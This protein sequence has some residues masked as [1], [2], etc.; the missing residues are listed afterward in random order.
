MSEGN[1]RRNAE[2]QMCEKK[3]TEVQMCWKA[4][5]GVVQRCRYVQERMQMCQ[6]MGGLAAGG[7]KGKSKSVDIYMPGT[8]T[9]WWEFSP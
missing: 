8:S 3:D 1:A 7:K 4:V 9:F 5:Q 2:V 6:C